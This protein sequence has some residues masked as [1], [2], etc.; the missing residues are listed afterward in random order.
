MEK[1]G[2]NLPEQFIFL[3]NRILVKS[4]DPPRFPARE[5]TLELTVRRLMSLDLDHDGHRFSALSIEEPENLPE[6]WRFID[7]RTLAFSAESALFC[8]VSKAYQL[9]YWEENHRYC[10]RCTG[11]LM[12][13]GDGYSKKCT[14]CGLHVFPQIAPAIIIGVVREGKLLMAHNVR[15]PEGVYSLVAGFL[16]PGET[17][18]ECAKREVMEET[19]I[20]VNNIRF[21]GSQPWPFP[22]S[23]MIGL[24]GVYA[25]GDIVPD[26]EEITDAKWYSPAE[27][28]KIPGR[29][30]ISRE[31][32]DWFV[33]THS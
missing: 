30:S 25:G 27:L 31:I 12:P 15:F 4:L 5:E 33:R 16:E 3:S 28:P 11:E 1:S 17:I 6:G 9:I 26:G 23:L 8:L 2:K 29:G 32:I 24:T 21:F 20:R 7:L 13:A 14:A 22:N 18:S 19:G 10:G